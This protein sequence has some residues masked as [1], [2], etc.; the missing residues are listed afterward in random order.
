MDDVQISKESKEEIMPN[1]DQADQDNAIQTESVIQDENINQAETDIQAKNDIQT[2]SINQ[3]KNA[4]QVSKN[5]TKGT[6]KLDET[7]LK[8]IDSDVPTTTKVSKK[9]WKNFIKQIVK[10]NDIKKTKKQSIPSHHLLD[11]KEILKQI[12]KL[13]DAKNNVILDEQLINHMKAYEFTIIRPKPS[14]V[15]EQQP[16][17]ISIHNLQNIIEKAKLNKET[18][19]EISG[20]GITMQSLEEAINA[21]SNK[22]LFNNLLELYIKL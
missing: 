3:T 5:D 18:T 16:K 17:I 19:L 4:D 7:T 10:Y 1:R 14:P 11:E 12:R 8:T 9:D 2:E 20:L 6:S 13:Y 15:I 21:P 22:E